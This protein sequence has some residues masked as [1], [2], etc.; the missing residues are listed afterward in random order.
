MLNKL[1]E[2]IAGKEKYE[3]SWWEGE[4]NGELN[5]TKQAFKS[6]L[7]DLRKDT[8]SIIVD[9][10]KKCVRR[11]DYSLRYSFEKVKYRSFCFLFKCLSA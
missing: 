3:E 4:K 10:F 7:G 6:L 5:A 8:P 11:A 2:I 1:V 9:L